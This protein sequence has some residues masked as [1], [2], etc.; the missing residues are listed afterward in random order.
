LKFK[1]LIIIFNI[2]AFFSL[3]AVV[4]LPF[5]LMGPGFTAQFWKTAWP[6]VLILILVLVGLNIFFL[7]NYR[8]LMLLEREDW[9][10]LAYYLEQ[11]V[12]VEGQYSSRKVR[13]LA[14]SY[15]VMGDFASVLQ[16]ES[17]T[18]AAKPAIIGKNA[19]VFGVARLLSGDHRGAATFFQACA[20][21]GKAED[22]Q[23]VRWF[24]GFSHML[25]GFFSEAEAEFTALAISAR[26][27]LITGL[28]AY[29]LGNILAKYSFNPQECR[30]ISEKGR[31]RVKKAFKNAEGWKKAAEKTGNEI[32]TAIIRKYI[33]EASPWLFGLQEYV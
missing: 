22:E 7:V 18:A 32:H 21:K 5:M 24:C 11:K 13:L 29:F 14:N 20:E 30:S 27:I 1:Y 9:P 3:F 28:S 6:I 23:W 2:I 19:L 15:L 25:A 12:F 10:A 16:L 8:L 26:N 17:K 4:L 31:D 33:D